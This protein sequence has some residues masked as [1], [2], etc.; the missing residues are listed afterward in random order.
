MNSWHKHA[1]QHKSAISWLLVV[2][3]LFIAILPS[4]FYFHHQNT[5]N[6]VPH[7]HAVHSHFSTNETLQAHE[8]EG[9]VSFTL[10]ALDKKN[11]PT[12]ADIAFI[13]ILLVLLP[14]FRFGGK[15]RTNVNQSRFNNLYYF[16]SPPLRAPPQP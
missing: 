5:E 8:K 11:N 16:I 14:F 12:F 1:I 6:I 3:I 2:A 9:A 10:F 7:E 4:R 13:S 15:I